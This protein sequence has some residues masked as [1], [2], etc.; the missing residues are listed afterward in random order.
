MLLWDVH[1]LERRRTEMGKDSRAKRLGGELGAPT[2]SFIGLA[3]QIVASSH[4]FGSWRICQENRKVERFPWPARRR[5]AWSSRLSHI[6]LTGSAEKSQSAIREL[7]FLCRM[8]RSVLHLKV[9]R[10]KRNKIARTN[11][12]RGTNSV[13]HQ[14]KRLNVQVSRNHTTDI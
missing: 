8:G 14:L 13:I 10:R 4:G 12:T 2:V 7:A 5:V 11:I 3:R 1:C 6:Q 9:R